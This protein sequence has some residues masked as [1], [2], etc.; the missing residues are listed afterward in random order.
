MCCQW[1][2]FIVG[3]V[4]S[5]GVLCIMFVYVFSCHV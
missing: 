4:I 1:V 5:T 2:L 3:G